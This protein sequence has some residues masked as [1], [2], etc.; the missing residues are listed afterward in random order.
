M[1]KAET[2]ILFYKENINEISPEQIKPEWLN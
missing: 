1:S 2:H